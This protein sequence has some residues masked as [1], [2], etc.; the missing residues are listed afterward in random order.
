M[1]EMYAVGWQVW[2]WIKLVKVW[3]S[4]RWWDVQAI[5]PEELRLIE[6]RLTTML[7]RKV[8]RQVKELPVCV[9][10]NAYFARLAKGKIRSATIPCSPCSL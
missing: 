1:D 8:N 9:S 10:E 6:G 3:A 5:L 4:W 2:A 7:R